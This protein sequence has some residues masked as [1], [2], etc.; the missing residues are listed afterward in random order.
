[1]R[2]GESPC[3]A[4]VD[5]TRECESS[6]TMLSQK[7]RPRM[8][9]RCVSTQCRS[10][11]RFVHELRVHMAAFSEVSSSASGRVSPARLRTS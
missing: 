10:A 2:T 3:P 9:P 8:K 4:A 1:M 5:N 6:S 7:L 11:T